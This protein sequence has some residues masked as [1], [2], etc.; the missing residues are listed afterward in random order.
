MGYLHEGHRSLLRTAR[1]QNDRVVLSIFVNPTQ[2]GPTEDLDAYPRDLEADLQAAGEESVDY[3]F[4][5]SE[6]AMYSG[7]ERTFVHVEELTDGLCGVSRPGHF[8]GV[9]TVVTK[10]FHLVQPTRAYFGEKDF[11]QL[12][13]IEQMVRDLNFGVEI[14]R[15]PLVREAEGLALSSRNAYLSPAERRAALVLF[16]SLQLVRDRVR[17]GCVDPVHLRREAV[18]VLHEEPLAEIDYVEIVDSR[19]LQPA[20]RI[21]DHSRLMLAVRVGATR[22]IDNG[23]LKPPYPDLNQSVTAMGE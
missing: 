3:V 20:G 22:L 12:V 9:T 17:S 15:C 5:P 16:R 13:V 21:D 8:R 4:A 2:F 19:D 11:Q 18:R 6:R 14:V 1:P 10:L 23:V 7:N